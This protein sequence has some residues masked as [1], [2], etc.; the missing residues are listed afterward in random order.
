[1]AHLEYSRVQ[2]LLAVGL[3]AVWDESSLCSG[4]TLRHPCPGASRCLRSSLW[5][6][7]VPAANPLLLAA[8]IAL[9]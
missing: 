6:R 3:S 8:P 1:M 5:A 9:R 7:W 4:P 2:H